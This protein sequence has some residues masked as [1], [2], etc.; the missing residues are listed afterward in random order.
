MEMNTLIK[1]W[2][3][4]TAYFYN[5]IAKELGDHAPAFYTQSPLLNLTCPPKVLVIGINP[6][7]GGSYREQ[8][9]NPLWELNG[10]PMDGLH[11][12]KG[13][14]CWSEHKKWRYWKRLRQMFGEDNNPMDDENGYVVTNASFF[15][16]FKAKELN[17]NIL[18]KTTPCSI[19][20]IDILKPQFILVLSGKSVLRTMAEVDEKTHYTQLF[21]SYSNVFIGD[22]HGVP[23]CGVSHPSAFMLSE[24]RDLIRKVISQVYNKESIVRENYDGLLATI[25]QRKNNPRLSNDVIFGLYKA[26]VVHDFPYE[27]YENNDKCRRYDLRNGFQ[28][29]IACNSTT[30]AIAIRPKVYKGDKDI[31]YAGEIFNCLEKVGYVSAHSWLAIKHLNQ[32]IFDDVNIEADRLVKEIIETIERVYQI[33]PPTD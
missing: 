17:K 11:L 24:E 26:I 31:P 16:T 5:V 29:T 28:L 27:C 3:D 6:G 25:N 22:I 18:K 20:L 12:I 10:N 33:L 7:S 8:C 9:N 19:E 2:A 13:N 23:C 4:R 21:N 32:L 1:N 15:A 30:K 14:P